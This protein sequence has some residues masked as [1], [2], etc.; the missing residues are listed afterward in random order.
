MG[1]ISITDSVANSF[2]SNYMLNRFDL[3]ESKSGGMLT[4]ASILYTVTTFVSGCIGSRKKVLI[5]AHE[6]NSVFILR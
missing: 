5:L 6:S 2:Y 1:T 3:S 4:V